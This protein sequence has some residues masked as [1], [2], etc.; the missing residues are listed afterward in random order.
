MRLAVV[1]SKV[2]FVHGGAEVHAQQLRDALVREGHET[3]LVEIPFKWYPP[4]KILDHLMACRLLDLTE[5]NGTPIDRV[6]GLKFPAYHIKHPN[7]VH[8]ILHQFRTAFDLWAS[9]EADLAYYP[10][11][12]QIRDAIEQVERNL[13]PEAR[14]IFTNSRNVS[15][16]LE[17]HCGIEST[18]LYHPPQGADAFYTKPAEDF[19]YYPSRLAPL[20]RQTLVLEALAH[21]QEPVRIVF[22]G[23]PDT[24]GY[25]KTLAQLADTFK[26]AGRVTWKGRVTEAEK[27]DLYARC[28][29]V[30]FPP[31]DEDY[32]YIT[33]EAML[34]AKPVIT[35]ADSGGPLEFVLDEGT[36]LISEPDAPSL[37]RKM[38]QLWKERAFAREAGLSG[39]SRYKEL[40]ISWK[41]VVEVLVHEA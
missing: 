21:C 19:L 26:V 11:G 34:A 38:D 1:T 14:A 9:P 12:R 23:N 28:L 20:K 35:C 36:G 7:K 39:E 4:E 15:E 24:P 17:A 13:L 41:R 40:G 33:L 16:R 32:G 27:L 5:S 8:W 18:P 30:V 10:E 31:Q 25:A 37:A 2:P 29:G 22:S 3:E 6:I